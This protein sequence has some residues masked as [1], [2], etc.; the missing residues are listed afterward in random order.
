M[1]PSKQLAKVLAQLEKLDGVESVISQDLMGS[2]DK[3]HDLL[4]N[5]AADLK[6]AGL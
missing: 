6:S 3:A 4:D 5:A 1:K 2:L